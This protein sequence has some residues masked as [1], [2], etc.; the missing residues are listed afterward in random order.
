MQHDLINE[1]LCLNKV[2][3]QLTAVSPDNLEARWP[4]GH[5]V[6]TNLAG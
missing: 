2:A 3:F 5:M 4:K 1:Q 6:E